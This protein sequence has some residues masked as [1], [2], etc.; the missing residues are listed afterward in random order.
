MI[1]QTGRFL[2]RSKSMALGLLAIALPLAPVVASAQTTDADA[3]HQEAVLEYIDGAT[4]EL[5]VYRHQITAASR[6]ENQQLLGE[7][8]AKLAECDRLVKALKSADDDQFDSIKA[9]YE[10]TR[11]GMIKALQAAQKT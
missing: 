10:R 2:S 4:K 9:S 3:L 11:A 5:D 1:P 8:K 7:A 6:P